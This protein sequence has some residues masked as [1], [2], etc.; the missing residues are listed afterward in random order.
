M[1]YDS[2]E[3]D[4]NAFVPMFETVAHKWVIKYFLYIF[5]HFVFAL[6]RLRGLV[7]TGKLDTSV[8]DDV[9]ERFRID[10]NQCPTFLL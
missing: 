3:P 6:P 10:E 9:S 7:N 5:Y 1:F 8:S 2:E 4:C